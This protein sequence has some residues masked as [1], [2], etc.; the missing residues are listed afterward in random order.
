MDKVAAK[1]EA[2]ES[3][4]LYVGVDLTTDILNEIEN[5]VNELI[6][7][8]AKKMFFIYDDFENLVSG[9]KIWYDLFNG[10]LRFS[11]RYPSRNIGRS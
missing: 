4:R 8:W 7:V 5:I 10:K 11:F 2:E 1:A 3:L 9:V 6:V